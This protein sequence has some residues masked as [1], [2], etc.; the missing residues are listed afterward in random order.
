MPKLLRMSRSL[1]QKRRQSPN[2]SLSRSS[3]HKPI[4]NPNQI[5]SP[6]LRLPLNLNQRPMLQQKQRMTFPNGN[7]L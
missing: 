2:C 4:Q 1:S 6:S 5:Q 7:L 3:R